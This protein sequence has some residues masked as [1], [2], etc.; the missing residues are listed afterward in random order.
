MNDEMPEK[1]I[2]LATPHLLLVVIVYSNSLVSH[3]LKKK[4]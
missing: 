3:L 1:K 4:T 2:F